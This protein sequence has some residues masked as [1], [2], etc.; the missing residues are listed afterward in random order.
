MKCQICNINEAQIVFTQIVDSEKVVM[1]ICLDCAR[2]RGLSIEFESAEKTPEM[3]GS[4]LNGK[5]GASDAL[6]R[7]EDIP[8]ITCKVC[9]LS[10]REF[11]KDGLF[12]CDGCHEAFGEHV[13]E[14]L[15][16]IHG[17]TE[18]QQIEPIKISPRAGARDELKKLRTELE[19]VIAS[20]EY[21]KAAE[22]RDRISEI[23]SR[24][25]ES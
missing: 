21:E 11:K 8:D 17:H 15:K 5:S 12:G 20:E 13:R 3:G 4:V 14:I 9:G 24:L 10:F 23:Q 16:K 7:D 6:S 19:M 18:H 2:E 22:L 1:Q 25:E